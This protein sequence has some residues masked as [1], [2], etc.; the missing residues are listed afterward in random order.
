M[1]RILVIL[2]ACMVLL[3]AEA[4][5]LHTTLDVL[6]PAKRHMPD[7]IANIIVVNNVFTQP[8]D[9]GHTTQV[10]GQYT[11]GIEVDLAQAPTLFLLGTAQTF[12]FSRLFSSVGFVPESQNTSES[13]FQQAPLTAE[14]ISELCYEYQADAALV[15]NQMLFY[16]VVGS[17]LTE[18]DDYY[19][20]LDAYLASKWTLQTPSGQ[21][22]SF[23]FNDTLYWENNA[24]SEAA[25]LQGL[26]NRQQ[27]LLD[28]S[29]YCGE[30]FANEFL[31]HWQTVDRYLYEDKNEE[32][33]RGMN[34]FVRKQWSQ[35]IAIWEGVYTTHKELRKNKDK[36]SAAYAAANIAVTYEMQDNLTEALRW[37]Q[38]AVE[39][40]SSMHTSSAAQQTINLRFYIQELER[41]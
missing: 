40:F 33:K 20:Y 3:S 4:Q 28:M 22:I 8:I 14:Q 12:D 34:A 2:V 37:A 41:R 10:S 1:K 25:A 32:L 31:P 39:V 19:A 15:C 13:F 30:K 27:A 7:S 9:F 21:S 36:T 6:M 38:Q 24:A 26:P 35:A 18:D 29:Q 11:S 23:T 5:Q 16:D 17:F